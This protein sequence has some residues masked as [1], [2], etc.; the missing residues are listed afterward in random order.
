M[1]VANPLGIQLG[2]NTNA[3]DLIFELLSKQFQLPKDL[4]ILKD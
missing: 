1:K 2:K 4:V 3:K